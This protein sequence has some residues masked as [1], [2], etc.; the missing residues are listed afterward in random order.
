MQAILDPDTEGSPVDVVNAE[1]T[2]AVVLACEHASNRIPRALNNLG[3]AESSLN[4][5]IAWDTGAAAVARL[6]ADRLDAALVMPRFS[7]LVVDCNRSPDADA[8]ILDVSDG[9]TIPGNTDLSCASRTA[10][11]KAIYAPF[12]ERLGHLLASRRNAGNPPVLATIH[13]FT[14]VM[15]GQTRDVD[16]GI[17]HDSDGRLADAV[18]ALAQTKF[19]LNVARNA[20]YSPRDGVTHTLGR[21]ALP[22]R[23][24][25]V[26]FEM[27]NTL[28]SDN[29][30]QQALASGLSEVL[31]DALVNLGSDVNGDTERANQCQ[32]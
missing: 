30:G 23:H 19:D 20:P 24:L 17:L 3:L 7:R 14:P 12:H 15:A 29:A 13:S 27:H 4:S 26:M 32:S 6:M 18:L 5:H 28:V 31:L 2:S 21:H 22:Y 8:A 10:R 25:N 9:C 1:G 11:H 16:I